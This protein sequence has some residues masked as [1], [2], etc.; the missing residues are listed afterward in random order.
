MIQTTLLNLTTHKWIPIWVM[1]I[2]LWK[3]NFWHAFNHNKSKR[4]LIL[5]IKT[6]SIIDFGFLIAFTVH[7]SWSVPILNMMTA[8][9]NQLT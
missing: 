8:I 5:Q 4:E 3:T 2:G 7:E 9:K 6:I 1:E